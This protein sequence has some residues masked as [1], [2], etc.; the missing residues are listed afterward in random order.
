MLGF[1]KLE[2]LEMDFRKSQRVSLK[3]LRY[4]FKQTS[5]FGNWR[6]Q[7]TNIAFRSWLVYVREF[8]RIADDRKIKRSYDVSEIIIV[9]NLPREKGVNS[10]LDKYFEKW[11]IYFEKLIISNNKLGESKVSCDHLDHHL[12]KANKFFPDSSDNF[13]DKHW[14][15]SALNIS[16]LWVFIW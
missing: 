14:T 5:S 8:I 1:R 10:Q 15:I 9:L 16:D 6:N 3:V 2:N 7:H 12:T 11:I 4:N 13:V